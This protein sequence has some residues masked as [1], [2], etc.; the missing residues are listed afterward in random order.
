VYLA[1]QY[2]KAS[3][4]VVKLVCF[5]ITAAFFALKVSQKAWK[6]NYSAKTLKVFLTQ[7]ATQKEGAAPRVRRTLKIASK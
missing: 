5:P 2:A 1:T 7:V 3:I 6:G 4:F